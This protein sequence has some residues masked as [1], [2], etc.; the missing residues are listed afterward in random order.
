MATR[1]QSIL[2]QAG[3][4]SRR[5]CED[6]IRQGHVLVNGKVASLG[7]AVEKRDVVMVDGKRI[8]IEKKVYIILNKPKGYVV[9]LND[10]KRRATV[11]ELVQV[12][13]RV[14]PVGRLDKDSEGL[15]LL[16]NDGELANMVLHPSFELE[17]EYQ[18]VIDKSLSERDRL[19]LHK[20]V[21]LDGR[22]VKMKV[23]GAQRK[24]SVILHEGRKRI[25]RRIF[26]RIGYKVLSLRRVR[27]GNLRLTKLQRGMWRYL[28]KKE[29][30]DLRRLLERSKD[31]TAAAHSA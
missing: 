17:K 11:M 10:E 25:L 30:D 4:G 15:L 5:Y 7:D 14:F 31:N 1:L 23:R 6:L 27:I 12:P 8:R 20:G 29:V 16:T 26:E 28:S 24:F 13:V 3:F 9:T 19:R 21:P 2:A 18:I 22:P